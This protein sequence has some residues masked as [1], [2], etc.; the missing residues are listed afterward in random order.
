MNHLRRRHVLALSWAA[1][2]GPAAR[3]ADRSPGAGR[4]VL[5]FLRGACD[6]LSALVPYADPYYAQLR[7][8]TRIASPDGTAESALRLDDRFALH[9]ALAPWMALWQQGVLAAVPAAGLPIPVRSHF[10]AQHWWEIAE[11]GRSGAADGWLNRLGGSGTGR[12]AQAIGVG[13][14]N[15]E[16]LRGPH[17]VRLVPSGRGATRAGVLER[18]RARAALMD[19]YAQSDSL[20]PAF[21][22]GAQ[23]RMDT[24]RTLE[25]AGMAAEMQAA[26]NGA[27][28]PAALVRDARHLA[29]LMRQDPSLRVGFLS[30]GGWDTHANQGAAT[31]QLAT[32]LGHLAQAVMALRE[33]FS[34]RDD[35]IVVASEFGRTAAENG[36]RGTDHGHGNVMWLIGQRIAG[37]RWHGQWD[38]L[39]SGDLHQG[40]DIPVRHDF[41]TV[42]AHVLRTT[43]GL[44]DAALAALFPRFTGIGQEALSAQDRPLAELMRG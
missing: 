7:A 9:P 39:A 38:G 40:R 30:A 32:N 6:G 1:L 24:A 29:V 18:D 37:G 36:S 19:L 20:G 27:A 26:D 23:S 34:R 41:R 14:A 3:A 10:E 12:A 8:S 42:L 25:G 15:P 35:V 11:P 31:G 13:E 21:R 43:Q 17:P 28:P 2:L 22:Q 33:E 4:F 16:A 44:D 5:V